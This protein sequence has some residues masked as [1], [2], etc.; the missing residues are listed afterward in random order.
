MELPEPLLTSDQ[1]AKWLAVTRES[2]RQ[3]V[4]CEEFPHVRLRRGSRHTLRFVREDVQQWID[5]R[6]G[7]NP[8]PERRLP[9]ISPAI[10]DGVDRLALRRKRKPR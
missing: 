6:S 3:Y 2:V 1:V 5:D 8:K 9:K 10:W 7:K 4:E